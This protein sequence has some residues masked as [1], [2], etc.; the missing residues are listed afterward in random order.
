VFAY[1][2]AGAERVYA[3]ELNP[4]SIEGLRRG[5][6]R[7]GIMDVQTL[8]P[9]ETNSATHTFSP[10]SSTTRLA[11]LPFS[12]DLGVPYYA[13]TA[14]H[15]NL[16]LLPDAHEGL[17]PAIQA[18]RDEGGWLHVHE[19]VTLS[20]SVSGREGR[21]EQALRWGEL[22]AGRVH[23]V[24]LR[25]RWGSGEENNRLE[26]KTHWVEEVKILGKDFWHLVADVRVS[27][28]TRQF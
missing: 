2:A 6:R 10:L 18:L 5:A 21:R 3:C 15:V 7:N 4:W 14:D 20:S 25:R 27:P 13:G 9:P 12:N 17:W 23:Q 11:I 1:L 19:S 26:V 28:G 22:V 8:P 24:A 16:G